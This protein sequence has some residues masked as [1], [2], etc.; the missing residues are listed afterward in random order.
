[1]S[2]G[3]LTLWMKLPFVNR[4][5]SQ[6]NKFAMVVK[7]KAAGNSKLNGSPRCKK[8]LFENRGLG[9]VSHLQGRLSLYTSQV[10]HQVTAYPGLCSIKQ[11]GVFLLPP[12]WDTSPS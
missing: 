8:W 6:S 3:P 10:A 9:L 2:D 4:P 5:H 7:I 11:L 12:G 1:M